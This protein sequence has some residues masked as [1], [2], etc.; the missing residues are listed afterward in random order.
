MKLLKYFFG[1]ITLILIIIYGFWF[2][3]QKNIHKTFIERKVKVDSLWE[4][5]KVD[6]D[7]RDNYF[8]NVRKN[9]NFD[10]IH[11]FITKSKR[12]RKEKENTLEIIQ[13]EYRVNK[14]MMHFYPNEDIC[15]INNSLNTKKEKYNEAV[16]SFNI[17]YFQIPNS[18]IARKYGLKTIKR[19]DL[20]YGEKNIDPLK[21]S[22]E[23]PE[24]AKE[25]DTL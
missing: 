1:G 16:K 12:E 8:M 7:N 23:L 10:S 15:I 3:F 21:K 14:S 17:F 11:H 25:R 19:F 2:F 4:D 24:W 18:I 22:K 5:F 13:N 20:I 9:E 6:L